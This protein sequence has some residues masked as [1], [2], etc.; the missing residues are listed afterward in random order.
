[1]LFV[2]GLTIV[3]GH[4]RWV[5]A[6]PVLVTLTGW[7]LFCGGLYRMVAP[8]AAQTSKPVTAYGLLAVLV[9]I[10]EVLTLKAYGADH[11][12]ADPPPRK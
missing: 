9:A 6:W 1:V 5:R 2:A 8:A 4:N 7:L 10:G 12:Q 11:S 3:Q